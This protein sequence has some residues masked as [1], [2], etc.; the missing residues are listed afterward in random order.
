M[1]D[2]DS[3]GISFTAGFF[4]LIAFTIAGLFVATLISIPIWTQMTGLPVSEMDKGLSDPAY[5]NVAKILQA[6]Q[7]IFGFFIPTLVTASLL[8]R[9]PLRLLGFSPRVKIS[10][11]GLVVLI[12]ITAMIVSTSLYYFNNNIP[13]PDSWKIKF[14]N[15]EKNYNEKAVAIVGLKNPGEY[16]LALIVMAF[17]PALCE[18][19]LFRGGLQNFLTRST[20]IPWLAILIASFI[21]SAIHLSW[22]L[23]IP[24]LFLG[25][26]LGLVYYYSGRLWLSIFAHFLNN[27]YVI[28]ALYISQRQGKSLKEAIV[29]NESTWWGI[30]ALPV[31]IGLLLVFKRISFNSKP[32]Y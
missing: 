28:T 24:R 2:N 29:N 7:A 21:F 17:L 12:L 10:Q 16:V 20:K 6:I 30:I 19:T 32:Q 13:I 15:W 8:N 11:A 22:Y 23:F 26:I 5:S 4:I 31:A 1:Y 25:I 18:E 9:K 14:D 27:A 3:K